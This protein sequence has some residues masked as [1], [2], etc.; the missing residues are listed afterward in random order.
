MEKTIGSL[1]IY[2]K[3]DMG[4]PWLFWEL[5]TNRRIFQEAHLWLKV[6]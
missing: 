3:M 2:C 1:A 6:L 4:N 5:S